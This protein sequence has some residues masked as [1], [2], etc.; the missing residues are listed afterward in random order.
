MLP[1]SSKAELVSFMVTGAACEG[2]APAPGDFP[3]SGAACEGLAPAPGDPDDE[4]PAASAVAARPSAV[5]ASRSAGEDGT[6]TTG[7]AL[8]LGGGALGAYRKDCVESGYS[9]PPGSQTAASSGAS[10][11]A[12]LVLTW[13]RPHRYIRLDGLD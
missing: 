3:V 8:T 2:L 4:Q 6:W 12:S 5:A 9:H 11:I 1:K 13:I 7:G 10:T